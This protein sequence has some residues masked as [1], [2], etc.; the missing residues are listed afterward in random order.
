MKTK[1]F[2]GWEQPY[3]LPWQGWSLPG[4]YST[5]ASRYRLEALKWG[6]GKTSWHHLPEVGEERETNSRGIGALYLDEYVA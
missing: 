1:V 3:W 5:T 2:S 6:T 4:D